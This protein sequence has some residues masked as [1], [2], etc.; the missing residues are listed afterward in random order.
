MIIRGNYNDAF[1]MLKFFYTFLAVIFNISYVLISSKFIDSSVY[2]IDFF[3][4][5]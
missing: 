4:H 3:F 2:F 1:Y 5:V